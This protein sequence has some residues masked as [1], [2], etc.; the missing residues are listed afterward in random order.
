MKY[1]KS[2]LSAIVDP[3]NTFISKSFPE[4]SFKICN[5]NIIIQGVIAFVITLLM[6]IFTR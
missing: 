2:V 1:V 5:K 6:M 3:I 4:V